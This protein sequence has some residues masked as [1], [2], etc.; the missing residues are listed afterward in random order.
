MEIKKEKIMEKNL[1]CIS[2]K[3]IGLILLGVIFILGIIFYIKSSESL[4]YR[5]EA[6]ELGTLCTK[7]YV[8][9]KYLISDA[10]CINRP[11]ISCM[12]EFLLTSSINC[13]SKTA[14]L[15][16][17]G[18][19]QSNGLCK[20]EKKIPLP[21]TKRVSKSNIF[22]KSIISLTPTPTPVSSKR[23][24]PTTT[25]ILTPNINL[26]LKIL[27]SNMNGEYIG[28]G[29][30]EFYDESVKKY[31][32]SLYAFAGDQT[33]TCHRDEYKK[34]S[35]GEQ[36]PITELMPT[37]YLVSKR[38]DDGVILYFLYQ[39]KI[40]DLF[41]MAKDAN[42]ILVGITNTNIYNV[43]NTRLACLED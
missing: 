13:K 32:G 30:F 11:E 18:C 22:K 19:D 35:I 15:C 8:N 34:T 40:Y 20:G 25:Q 6:A 12:S 36:V 2:K 33:S 24:T 4:V 3:I 28:D 16:Y 42:H 43:V 9:G 27:D 26:I 5:T 21:M 7:K 38:T 29:Y 17:L 1:I 31:Y 37:F 10:C 14:K 41:T 39:D 23:P